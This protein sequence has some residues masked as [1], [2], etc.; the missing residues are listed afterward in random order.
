MTNTETVLVNRSPEMAAFLQ[1]GHAVEAFIER[2]RYIGGQD[3]PDPSRIALAVVCRRL[4]D[5]GDIDSLRAAM[6]AYD[7]EETRQRASWQQYRERSDAERAERERMHE[8]AI[9]AE[10]PFC[11]AQPGS[12]CRT[13]GPSGKSYSKGI[14][15]HVDRVRAATGTLT[16][17]PQST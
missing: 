8:L 5:I 12:P 1:F 16:R 2:L 13:A 10:C 4:A 15:H 9:T 7:E 6:A 11:G 3:A 17:S 14:D